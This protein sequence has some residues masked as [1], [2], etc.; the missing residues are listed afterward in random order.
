MSTPAG[1]ELNILALLVFSCVMVEAVRSTSMDFQHIMFL[2]FGGSLLLTL[3]FNVTRILVMQKVISTLY[4][5]SNLYFLNILYY[6][7]FLVFLPAIP[8]TI[9]ALTVRNNHLLFYYRIDYRFVPGRL[10]WVLLL[11]ILFLCIFGYIRIS[12]ATK[13]LSVNSDDWGSRSK[14]PHFFSLYSISLCIG[15]FLHYLIPRSYFIPV[16]ST[17]GIVMIYT[18]ATANTVSV[19]PLTGINNRQN[20]MRHIKSYMENPKDQV[21]LAM[22][23]LN[24][25]KHINDHY[26]HVVGDEVLC[27]VADSL[28]KAAEGRKSHP[29]VARFG[30]D[31]FMILL[32]TNSPG[33][34]GAMEVILQQELSERNE[35]ASQGKEASISIGWAQLDPETMKTPQQFIA[36]ADAVLY[37]NKSVWK[38][39]HHITR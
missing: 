33:E 39:A 9:L 28:K 26:G 27:R 7:R 5:E 17:F 2:W 22:L 14:F 23:D 35:R 25:F 34:T 21:F 16:M 15:V 38:K 30:G 18:S 10:Y 11:E 24:D 13:A 1:P 4:T 6:K 36:A 3:F 12:R 37:K 32:H 19:D 31:E 29:Y 8:A 20:L